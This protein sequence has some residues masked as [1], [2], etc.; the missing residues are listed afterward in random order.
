MAFNERQNK[1]IRLM[2]DDFIEKIR[3]E[4]EIRSQFDI[5]YRIEDQSIIIFEIRPQ[6]DNKEIIRH[7]DTAKATY[8]RGTKEW[9]IFW[10]KSNMKWYVYKYRP[11]VDVLEE[12]LDIVVEDKY[13]YFW[14]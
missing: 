2:M 12:F 1:E 8:N 10:L 3:P 6:W 5:S 7:Y 4:E 9:S 11:V 13:Y 14:G